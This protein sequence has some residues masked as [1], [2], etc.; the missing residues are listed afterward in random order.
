MLTPLPLKG[1]EMYQY[2]IVRIHFTYN[3]WKKLW[4]P[5]RD[6]HSII[7]EYISRGWRLNSILSAPTRG[8]F[9]GIEYIE[10]FFERDLDTNN[11]TS[12]QV[13]IKTFN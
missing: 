10:I 2:E 1:I 9:G 4:Q 8:L 7:K 11:V 12:E 6:Y 13:R 3:F 5:C